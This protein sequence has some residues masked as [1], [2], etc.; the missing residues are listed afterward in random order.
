MYGW[1]LDHVKDEDRR[2]LLGK[3][4]LC[5]AAPHIGG[6]FRDFCKETGRIRRTAERHLQSEFQRISSAIIKFPESLQE[7]DWSR[8][9][10]MMPNSAIDLD[11]VGTPVAKHD[12]HWLPG[13]AKPF[14]DADSP[15]L[16]ALI[17]RL[18]KANRK[19]ARS[20]QAV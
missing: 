6:S 7:P 2:V 14:H 5:L 9:S 4:S 18:E 16:A 20:R 19:R 10:P 1:L 17:K 15:E 8:V 13:D 11:K 12:L 3:W